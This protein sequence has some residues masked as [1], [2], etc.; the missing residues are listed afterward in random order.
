MS[1]CLH[2]SLSYPACNA[3]TPYY[4]VIFELAGSTI[5]FQASHKSHDFRGKAF[6]H[7]ISCEF[8]YNVCLKIVSF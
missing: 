3:H 2:S 1:L 4:T 8:F 6:E 5:L 7:K